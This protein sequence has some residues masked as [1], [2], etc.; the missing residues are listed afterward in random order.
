METQQFSKLSTSIEQLTFAQKKRLLNSLKKNIC[1]S[2]NIEII[3]EA[4]E[5]SQCCPHC[6]SEKLQRWGT[7]SDLQRYRCKSCKKTFNALTKSP[8]ARLRHKDKV[9]AKLPAYLL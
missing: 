1:A 8:L 6:S 5:K 7:A 2:E 4:F 3:E 9:S